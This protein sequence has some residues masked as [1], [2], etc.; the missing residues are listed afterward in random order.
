MLTNQRYKMSGAYFS[1]SYLYYDFDEVTATISN[2]KTYDG[3][4]NPNDGMFIDHSR[5]VLES[6]VSL[7]DINDIRDSIAGLKLKLSIDHG[8]NVN[9]I[10]VSINGRFIT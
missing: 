4:I 3:L 6:M 9:D 1:S 7:D 8:L 2:L 10:K 5:S